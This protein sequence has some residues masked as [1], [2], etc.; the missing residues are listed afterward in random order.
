MAKAIVEGARTSVSVPDPDSFTSHSGRGVSAI[1]Q[2]K[3]VV[4]G[5]PRSLEESG[6]ALNNELKELI[7]RHEAQSETT[8]ILTV[9]GRIEGI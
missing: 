1:V 4:V 6:V 9:D 8:V 7:S 2:G 5:S 3:T